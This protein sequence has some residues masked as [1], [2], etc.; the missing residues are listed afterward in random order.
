MVRLT[1]SVEG[2][3]YRN[4]ENGYTVL[5]LSTP[6][7]FETV[8]GTFPLLREGDFITVFGLYVEHESYG[9]QFKATSYEMATPETE[10]D[11]ENYLASGVISGI[12]PKTARDIVNYFG[13]EALNVIEKT[14]EKLLEIS[15]I[16]EKKLE[17]IKESFKEAAG[18]RRTVMFLQK[19]GL[20]PK[21]AVKIY[22]FYGDSTIEILQ[23]NPYKLVKDIEG[24]GFLTA[25]KIASSLGMDKASQFRIN[26]GIIY[27][28]SDAGN[29]GH[30]YLPLPVVV[31]RAAQLL[32]VDK[33]IVEKSLDPLNAEKSIIIW[34]FEG[35]YAVYHPAFFFSE[36]VVAGRLIQLREFKKPESEKKLLKEIASYENE[37]GIT[38]ADN[39]RNAVISAVNNGVSIITGGPGTGKTTTLD[40]ILHLY[41]KRGLDIALCA[42]TGRAAKRMSNATGEDAKT[43][44]R[45]LEYSKLDD[46]KMRFKRDKDNPL[47]ADVV[48]V[49]EASMIDIFL[50]DALLSGVK[51]GT[52]LIIVGDS[53]QLP[54]VGAGNVLGDM[55]ASN[56]FPTV[57]LDVIFRQASESMII[58]N[59]HKINNG[60]MP[61]CNTKGSDFFLDRR[62]NENEI[63]STVVD[64]VKRRLPEKYNY[65]PFTDIQVLTPVKKGTAGV[66]NLNKLLQAALNP[67]DAGKN[68]HVFNEDV[69]REGD[70]VMQIRNNYDRQWLLKEKYDNYIEGTGVFNGDSGIIREIDNNAKE[71]TVVFD[72][73]RI[74]VYSFQD[75]DEL[76]L[77]Y[78][79][80]VHK[81]QGCEFPVAVMPLPLGNV[82]IMNR[83]LLYTAVTRASR[84][85]VMCGRDETVMAAVN[86]VQT[87][88]RYS[89]L[90]NRLEIAKK[91][92]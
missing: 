86:N 58:T 47:D 3:I 69:F 21:M 28:L 91:Y 80:S 51:N 70:K 68:E 74:S 77:S 73:E 45:L 29:E 32:N 17:L 71:M 7:A 10:D 48:I 60:E 27:S 88:K 89:A 62:L 38:L 50:M 43:V 76:T 16:G 46:G 79:I 40:C 52:R 1:G 13:K 15:G 78:A 90:K 36:A 31:S 14:P 59:A 2:I 25:D 67:K 56:A 9:T 8:V 63:A 37:K 85:V 23:E 57:K 42:P 4:S 19:Y 72:D 84:L 34:N 5:V 18:A 66:F 24:I 55:I 75:M 30:T 20:T 22:T 49:D 54:S 61:V 87:Q 39:Q 11:I 12:G 33:S 81:S 83:N 92:T 41:R 6:D 26:A 82:R 35:E 44:H 65:S 53:D 64:I